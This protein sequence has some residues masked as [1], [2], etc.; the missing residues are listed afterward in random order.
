MR[1]LARDGVEAGETGAAGLGALIEVANGPAIEGFAVGEETSA[2]VLCTEGPTD[3]EAYRAIVGR[4]A[5]SAS[6]T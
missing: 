2:L 5:S 4:D 3:P 6:T 1:M